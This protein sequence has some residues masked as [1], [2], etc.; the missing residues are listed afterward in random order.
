M[1]GSRKGTRVGKQGANATSSLE[2]SPARRRAYARRRRAEEARWAAL[3]G[4]VSAGDPKS[5]NDAWRGVRVT[6]IAAL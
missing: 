4:P 3:A 5:Q 6:A 1:G 2:I